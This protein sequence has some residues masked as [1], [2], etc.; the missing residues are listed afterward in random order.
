MTRRELDPWIEGYL[1]YLADVRRMSHGTVKDS[2]CTLAKAS[3]EME[4][5]HSGLTLWEATLADYLEWLRRQRKARRSEHSLAKDLSHIRGL[6][7]YTWRSG[8]CERNVLDGFTLKDSLRKI[9]PRVLTLEEARRLVTACRRNTRR[10]RRD[11]VVVL[12]LYGCGLRTSELCALDVQDVDVERQ[13]LF[14]RRGKGD[15]ERTVPVPAA[16]WTELLAYRVER[17]G[18]RGALFRTE[19][20]RARVSVRIVSQIVRET[21]ARAGIH[22][23]VVPKTLRHTYGT[24][25]MEQGV[26]LAV[27]ASLMGHRSP[28]ETGVYL[29]VLPGRGKE[30]VLCLED[31]DGEG[32]K[33]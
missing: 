24:H 14:I 16:V 19:A 31:T 12:L 10:E 30:A 2:R 33:Q 18:K 21:A 1:G 4:A 22:G 28:Q 9:P 11:R 20:K 26:D 5:I 32:E 15:R 29:H 6:L 3:R 17:G 7:D 13:E 23:S 8:R 27:I 25:L